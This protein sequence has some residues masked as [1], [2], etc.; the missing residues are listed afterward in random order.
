MTN[1]KRVKVLAV[2]DV[3]LDRKK[4]ERTFELVESELSKADL[5]LGNYEA[6]LSNDGEQAKFR[7]WSNFLYSPPE[8]VAGLTEAGF[9]AVSLANN[10]SMNYGPD[11][12]LDTLELLSGHRIGVVGA[13]YN[14]TDAERPYSRTI[15]GLDIG[16]LGFESTWWDWKATQASEGR[17]GI[18]QI[19][20][21][22]YFGAPFVSDYDLERM[23][24][25]IE[26]AAE[27]HDVLL[28]MFHFGIAGERQHTV[29]QTEIAHRAIESGA[30]A[31]IGAHSHT[32]QAVEVY[33]SAPIFYSAGNFAFDR[34]DTWSLDLMPSES[35][36]LELSLGAD[37]VSEAIFKPAVNDYGYRNRPKILAP[38]DEDYRELVDLLLFLSRRTGTELTKTDEGLRVPL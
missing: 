20:I 34:P 35:G 33:Q 8:M 5:L 7:P 1:R 10:Q 28:T 9:D 25:S 37:G 2:G 36:V 11:G 24:A 12:L 4:P 27:A 30:D 23:Q 38:G 26:A 15:D 13:G 31:V 32:L 14:R 21:S 22:P 6:S 19:S 16:V 18:N 29:A 17:A 3:F